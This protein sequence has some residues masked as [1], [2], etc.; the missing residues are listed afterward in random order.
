MNKE[1]FADLVVNLNQLPIFD[2]CNGTLKYTKIFLKSRNLSEQ[3]INDFCKYC[4]NHGGYCDCEILYNTIEDVFSSQEEFELYE[5]K[6]KEKYVNNPDMQLKVKKPEK[7]IIYQIPYFIK[8]ELNQKQYLMRNRSF[9]KYIKQIATNS[10]LKSKTNELKKL[11][12][13]NPE[14]ILTIEKTTQMFVPFSNDIQQA[15]FKD[16]KIPLSLIEVEKSYKETQKQIMRKRSYIALMNK[17]HD[18]QLVYVFIG[19]KSNVVL[20]DLTG[21]GYSTKEEA[22]QFFENRKK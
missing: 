17:F 5:E 3:D 16:V 22:Q 20:K 6:A 9:K 13:D 14:M 21:D 1:L 11:L 12:S 4:E 15:E 18:K 10:D 2:Y 7:S 19:R 8:V